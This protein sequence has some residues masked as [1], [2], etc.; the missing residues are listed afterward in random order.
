[1][2]Y[3][4][5]HEYWF[6]ILHGHKRI[7]SFHK[8]WNIKLWK[9]KDFQDKEENT[10]YTDL[11]SIWICVLHK[12][13]LTLKLSFDLDGFFYFFNLSSPFFSQLD[14]K[15]KSFSDMKN[16]FKYPP[17]Y[18]LRLCLRFFTWINK[19]QN[20]QERSL[21]LNMDF[22]R[23]NSKNLIKSKVILSPQQQDLFQYY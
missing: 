23:I 1:M 8:K 6:Q 18:L 16:N 7:E 12:S 4:K 20:N 22:S 14:N 3:M 21:P 17:T 15:P 2:G 13:L 9:H 5:K 11:S 10:Y 19:Q